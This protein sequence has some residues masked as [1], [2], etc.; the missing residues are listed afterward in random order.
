M[1]AHFADLVQMIENLIDFFSFSS[2]HTHP[3]ES[4]SALYSRSRPLSVSLNF[5]I[6]PPSKIER[7]AYVMAGLVAKPLSVVE[8]DA[9]EPALWDVCVQQLRRQTERTPNH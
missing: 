3:G 1:E 8:R 4:F 6:C 9:G 7:A 5:S 2:R